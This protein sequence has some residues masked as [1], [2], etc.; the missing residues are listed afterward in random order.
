[1]WSVP[2]VERSPISAANRTCKSSCSYGSS[3]CAQQ[4]LYWGL[5]AS[6]KLAGSS[7]ITWG[8]KCAEWDWADMCEA[9]LGDHSWTYDSYTLFA[10]FCHTIMLMSSKWRWCLQNLGVYTKFRKRLVSVAQQLTELGDEI[11]HSSI[12]V[13]AAEMQALK[14]LDVELFSPDMCLSHIGIF[15]SAIE[16]VRFADSR[17]WIDL[18]SAVPLLYSLLINDELLREWRYH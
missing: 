6:L 14:S 16:R 15:L 9:V 4:S 12:K 1:M 8:N 13:V 17:N 10:K 5:I 2:V 7:R 11:A 3:N 18:L